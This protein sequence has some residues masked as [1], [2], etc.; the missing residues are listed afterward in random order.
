MDTGGGRVGTQ[1]PADTLALA[2]HID[3]LPG[4]DFTGVMTYPSSERARPFLDEVRE[5]AHKSGLPLH[6]HQ[7]RRHRQRNHLQIPR[8]HRDPH[9]L[10]RLRGHDPRGQA[11]R[12]STPPAARCA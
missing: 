1:S 7:R 5:G 6:I 3:Q 2:Q 8:L 11:R 10:V 12:T 9:R 4:L